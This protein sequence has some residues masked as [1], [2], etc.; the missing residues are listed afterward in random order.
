MFEHDNLDRIHPKVL[1]HA[2]E[3]S[4]IT[5]GELASNLG[6][7]IPKTGK[8]DAT[9]AA[10]VMERSGVSYDLAIEFIEACHFDPVDYGL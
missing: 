5:T 7:I 6:W 4:G 10:R 8:P 1:R 9:R 3:R 2:F